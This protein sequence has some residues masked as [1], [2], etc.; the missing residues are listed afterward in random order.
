MRS[1]IIGFFRP[2]K[3]F[4]YIC[5]DTTVS[6]LIDFACRGR[7][8]VTVYPNS[9][10]IIRCLHSESAI[11]YEIVPQWTSRWPPELPWP[12]YNWLQH[13]GHNSATNLPEK[14]Q[15]VHD[16]RQHLIDMWDGVEQNNV[17][18]GI[19]QW[20]TRLYVC[21]RAT[22]W[23]FESLLSRKLVKTFKWNLYL[24]IKETS[25]SDYRVSW[26]LRF[27]R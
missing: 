26:H 18:A 14:A 9:L 17:L 12:Q 15:D 21:V 1:R 19:D 5:C 25:L 13:L 27:T 7:F 23:Y 3:R 10:C 2:T 6:V 24:L 22:V 4:G 11:I 8:C 16:V 20:R